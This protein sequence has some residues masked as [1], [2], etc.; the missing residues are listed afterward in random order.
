MRSSPDLYAVLHL[1]PQATPAEVHRAYR[2]LLRRHHPD[3]R[4]APATQGE[5]AT[6]HEMLTQIMD[7]HAVL[8]DPIRRARY[9]HN[10]PDS[11]ISQSTD[12]RDERTR[13]KTSSMGYTGTGLPAAPHERPSIIV[14]PLRWGPPRQGGIF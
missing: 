8:A 9:D 5:A 3:T 13:E 6:K 1:D 10:L 7:A 12:R 2:S 14:G 4:P 11:Q